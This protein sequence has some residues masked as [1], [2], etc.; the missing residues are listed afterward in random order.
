MP[1][2]RRKRIFR[3]RRFLR[4][5]RG[6]VFRG[7][8][9]YRYRKFKGIR[10]R[11]PS[12]R[13]SNQ[14][15]LNEKYKVIKIDLPL[16][17]YSAAIYP[18]GAAPLTPQFTAVNENFTVQ[19]LIDQINGSFNST[20]N[21]FKVL[22]AVTK[23]RLDI[24]NKNDN[25]W[26]NEAFSGSYLNPYQKTYTN[27]EIDEVL[28]VPYGRKHHRAGG[29][30]AWYPKMLTTTTVRDV[31]GGDNQIT[32]PYNHWISGDVLTD[33][34]YKGL[35]LLLPGVGAVITTST[36]LYVPKWQV[37][38]T[39]FIGLKGVNDWDATA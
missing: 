8:R 24:G 16:A 37:S 34:Q 9:T 38:T 12:K 13:N 35:S 5:G 3:R 25:Y 32:T 28:H 31:S 7:R 30:R 2:Y 6:R 23:F 18:L 4:K 20:Y 1:R 27:L 22:R 39:V 36:S 29:I 15:L 14:Q 21:E 17:E 19:T 26:F 10:G 33:T 11:A